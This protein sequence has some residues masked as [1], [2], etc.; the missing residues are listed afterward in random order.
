MK[1]Q[2]WYEGFVFIGLFIVMVGV[3]CFFTA[4][5]GVKLIDRLGQY[6]SRSAKL[7]MSVCIQLLMVEIVG[8]MMQAAFFH[9][10]SD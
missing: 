1:F 8:F 10:F 4:I 6:P 5:L 7:Q 2:F 9:F 3:P